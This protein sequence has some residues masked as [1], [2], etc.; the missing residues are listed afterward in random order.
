MSAKEL[1]ILP[2]IRAVFS[3][4]NPIPVKTAMN[5]MG[6]NAG[7]PRLPLTE[8]EPATVQALETEMKKLGII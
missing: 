5:L 7:I 6:L 4:V 3:E 2:L 1:K 8:A